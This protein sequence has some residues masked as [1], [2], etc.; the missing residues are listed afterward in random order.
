[1]DE[2]RQVSYYSHSFGQIILD[3]SS[4]QQPPLDYWIGSIFKG[5]SGTDFSCRLPAALFGAGTVLLLMILISKST[6]LTV[7][8]GVG[9]IASFS[10]FFLYFS[11]DARP[12]SIAIFF[13]LLVLWS[14]DLLLS[15]KTHLLRNSFIF[16]FSTTGFLYSRTLSPL[17]VICVLFTW[18][19]LSL[20]FRKHDSKRIS[21]ALIAI[22]SAFSIYWPSLKFIL[23]RGG[24]YVSDTGLQFGWD[25]IKTLLDRFDLF[26]L[27]KAFVVQTEPSTIPLL[28][29][30][31]LSVFLL[32][33]KKV[34]P[35][36]RF[37]FFCLFMLCVAGL[38]NLLIFQAKTSMPFRPPYAIYLLPLILFLSGIG[39]QGLLNI[40]TSTRFRKQIRFSIFM[41]GSL[42]IFQ[43][44]FAMADFKSFPKKT[45]WRGLCRH[46]SV[47]FG[48]EHVLFFDSLSPYG[49]WEPT[50]FGFQ[51]YYRG[52]SI[53]SSVYQIPYE[54]APKRLPHEPILILFQWREYFL[55]SRSEYP[56]IP[57]PGKQM[58]PTDY[59]LI[60][61]DP[62][63]RVT[64]LSGFSVIRLK[65]PTGSLFP[66]TYSI[67]KRLLLHL[68]EDS[69][70]IEIHLATGA[71][72]K[73]LGKND[74]E[75][76]L[77][78]AINLGDKKH[79]PEITSTAER[80]RSLTD[81]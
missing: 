57:L 54:V 73:V 9:L 53:L 81:F 49:L 37:P 16:L 39:F 78:K 35:E 59:T 3:A 40:A 14:L 24:R 27:W 21:A 2:L 1:M 5:F 38:L 41:I 4:Q 28:V 6:G 23:A 50:F 33:S 42:M 48:P 26:P 29:L 56:F 30:S 31:I 19:L 36:K 61:K 20:F 7:T 58:R 67:L 13:F 18:L 52:T 75:Y 51:R 65:N 63:L 8:A 44:I 55:T 25:N 32:F 66:D 15:S 12:Y 17:V 70:N 22:I 80:I 34:Y 71:I 60:S 76:H 74:W 47:E 79:R 62:A 77:D 68:P 45:D 11:Q 72:A 64:E 46:L 43:T 10:P 69:A